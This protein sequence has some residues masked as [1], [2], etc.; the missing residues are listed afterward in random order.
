MKQ[1]FLR[2]GDS[3]SCTFSLSCDV[4]NVLMSLSVHNGAGGGYLHND[5]SWALYEDN[6]PEPMLILSGG[7]PYDDVLCVDESSTY[8]FE[9]H[10]SYVPPYV[11]HFVFSVPLS[12]IHSLTLSHRVRGSPCILPEHL[13]NVGRRLA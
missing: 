11:G 10:D 9:M 1:C 7:A 5:I 6:E 2:S 12:L 3:G 13:N 4:D 8:T